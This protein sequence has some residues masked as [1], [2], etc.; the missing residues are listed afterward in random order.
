LFKWV[1]VPVILAG[2]FCLNTAIKVRLYP[3]SPLYMS[4]SAMRYRY[5]NMIANNETVPVVDEKIQAPEG[6]RVRA[7]D[8]LFED[9]TAGLSYRLLSKFNHGLS[10]SVYLKW[11][12]CTFSSLLVLAVFLV[13]AS[14][15][16]SRPAGLVAAAF[17]AVSIPSFE[18]IIGNYLR[19]EFALP[20]IFFSLYFFLA[21]I[22]SSS[23]RR[24]AEVLGACSGIFTFLALS[25]W[26][27]S[28]FYFLVFIVI[29]V[30]V[31]FSREELEPVMRPA[32]YTVGFAVLAGLVNEALR[33]KMFL[34]SFPMIIGYCMVVAY[35]IWLRSRMG[36]LGVAAV[37]IPVVIA[38]I[39]LVGLLS[40]NRQE[41]GHVYSLVLAKIRF[42]ADKPADP[43]RLPSEARLLWLGP[44][45]SPSLFG[46]LYGFGVIFL[47]SLYPAAVMIHRWIR[48]RTAQTGEMILYMS[49][50]F[51][52]LYLLIRRLEVFAIFFI[53]VLIGGIC[54][55]V[56]GRRLVLAL[57]VLLIIFGFET[58]KAFTFAGETPI[59]T[60]LLKIKRP[61]VE[62]PSIHDRDKAEIFRWIKTSTPDSAVFL[63]RFPV[64]P[65]IVTYG[66][67]AAILQPVFETSQIR[68]K[69]LECA[70]SFYGMEEDVYNVCRKYGADFVLYE[71]NQ[72]LDNSEL[73]DR[74]LTNNLKTM[75]GSAAFEMQFAPERLQYF[76]PVCQ[77][78]YFRVFLVRDKPG[79]QV[80]RYLMYSPQYDPWLF[81][82]GK[83]G[84]VFSDSLVALAW[85]SIQAAVSFTQAG[86]AMMSDGDFKNAAANFSK[87][88]G[89]MPRLDTARFALAECYSRMGEM[90]LCLST[91]KDVVKIDPLNVQAYLGLAAAYETQ[92]LPAK[93][94]EVLNEGL[95][96]LPYETT[97]MTEV[98]RTYMGLGDK[99]KA[100]EQ[101]EKVLSIEPTNSD[102]RAELDALKT[103]NDK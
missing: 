21:S 26:H 36:R 46:F 38:S 44:F 80:P 74:Y 81:M 29:A 5:A 24:Q 78:D 3:D 45:Q 4:D 53:V 63:A 51:F 97:L 11:F 90:D 66:E 10:F 76:I 70:S 17:Y 15:W 40:P 69:V 61:E 100:I 55:L 8:F 57:A 92:K 58:Y 28:S 31:A 1:L 59:K 68:H 56:K 82:A 12:V 22:R 102:V 99:K 47:V 32:M 83:M 101:Y 67:R 18:R 2:L 25:S 52:L 33:T 93:A 7:L 19:E 64:S 71:A 86:A 41:F 79:P 54:A 94:L 48:R 60:A 98:A 84:P 77:T 14:V 16:E 65:M 49:V 6:L 96:I 75:T 30:L 88:L 27:L 35:A 9:E 87:A 72:L 20:F 43:A 103:Q 62:S 13:G 85:K 23:N 73:G 91:Y 39:V 95:K 34:V 89:L 42:L 50:A 37:F